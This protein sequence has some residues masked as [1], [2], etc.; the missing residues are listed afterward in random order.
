MIQSSYKHSN[1]SVT[2]C[3]LHNLEVAVKETDLAWIL[4]IRCVYIVQL[5]NE[6]ALPFVLK[7]KY[8]YIKLRSHPLKL[9]F[10][11]IMFPNPNMTFSKAQILCFIQIFVPNFFSIIWIQ[12]V[13]AVLMRGKTPFVL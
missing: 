6:V 5:S 7:V 11:K 2:Y 1:L 8:K 13:L 4:C 12:N 10:P 3:H 9:M